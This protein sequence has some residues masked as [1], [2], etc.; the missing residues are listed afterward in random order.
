MKRSDYKII[1]L[2][3]IFLVNVFCLEKVFAQTDPM[4]KFVTANEAYRQGNY[5]QAALSYEEII[6]EGR[7]SGAVYYNLG[8][9]YLKNNQLGQAILNYERA[10][11]F[12]PRDKDLIFN[13]RYAISL[14]KNAPPSKNFNLIEKTLQDHIQFYTAGGMVMI[15]TILL[16]LLASTQLLSL[17]GRWPTKMRGS[18]LGVLGLL[19]CIYA[20]GLVAKVNVESDSAIILKDTESHF[21]PVENSTVYFKLSEGTKVKMIETSDGWVKLKRLD[22][23][24]GW[25]PQTTLERI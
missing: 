18:V 3:I 16:G 22:D 4:P 2:S 11:K 21:E 20:G 24:M 6:K 7:V 15:I 14:I 12:I 25:V 9:S 10:L 8:N 19:I 13:D 5:A 17:Y 1:F 23:K